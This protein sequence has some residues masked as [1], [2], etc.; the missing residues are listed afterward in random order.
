MSPYVFSIVIPTYNRPDRLA[1][2][3]QSLTQLSYPRDRFE[4]IVVDDGSNPSIASVAK[5]FESA[6]NISLLRQDN[7][8]P[9]SARNTGAAQAQ[10]Q[11]LVFT[12][13]DCQP[14]PDWLTALETTLRQQPQALVGGYTVNALPENLFSTASQLLIDYLYDYYN[15]RHQP[16]F[17]A[18]N[19][20][21]MATEQFRLLGGFDTSFPLAAGEYREFCDRWLQ[22]GLPLAYN[23]TARVRHTHHL[24]LRRFWRQHFNYGRGAYCF[25]QARARRAAEQVKVEPLRFYWHLLTYPLVRQPQIQGILLSGLLL[26]S[27]VANV[28]G[29]FWE[30]N[31][32]RAVSPS[33]P[34]ASC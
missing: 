32:Q 12:D 30:R 9:A 7:G 16:S 33:T 21:A 18:S 4:V 28:V 11:Y 2:C 8:G 34:A 15:R 19:N 29:F 3:L 6:L 24:S 10:G 5:P 26:L 31:Q 17:F 25:H 27:Q 20:F 13:D 23:S 1:S 22:Q 14:Y